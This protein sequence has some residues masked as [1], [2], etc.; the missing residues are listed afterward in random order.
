MGWISRALQIALC[1]NNMSFFVVIFQK[2]VEFCQSNKNVCE[3]LCVGG[4]NMVTNTRV[5][6]KEERKRASH[7]R[8]SDTMNGAQNVFRMRTI[9]NG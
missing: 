2:E 3:C 4:Q 1:H 5:P 9:C 7:V 8:L 6:R